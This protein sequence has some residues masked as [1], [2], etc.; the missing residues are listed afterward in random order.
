[1]GKCRQQ[2]LYTVFE[3]QDDFFQRILKIWNYAAKRRVIVELS[4]YAAAPIS[5]L[6]PRNEIPI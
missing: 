4:R 6:L 1:M 2:T 3:S 5:C